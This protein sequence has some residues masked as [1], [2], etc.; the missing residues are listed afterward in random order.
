[1]G[2]TIGFWSSAVRLGVSHDFIGIRLAMSGT[3]IENK[4][5]K[6]H[7]FSSSHSPWYIWNCLCWPKLA[8]FA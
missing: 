2:N 1:V 7:R 8:W 3:P 4:V 5:L 6:L